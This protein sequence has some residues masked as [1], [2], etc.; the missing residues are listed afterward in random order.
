MKQFDFVRAS[1]AKINAG[2]APM[3]NHPIQREGWDVGKSS[4]IGP[5]RKRRDHCLITSEKQKLWITN[6]CKIEEWGI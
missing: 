3:C 2:D 6:F 5:S 1:I 4:P